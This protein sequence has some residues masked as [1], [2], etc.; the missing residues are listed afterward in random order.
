M[1]KNRGHTKHVFASTASLAEWLLRFAA[2]WSHESNLSRPEAWK[3]TTLRF[4]LGHLSK[5]EETW[6]AYLELDREGG[7]VGFHANRLSSGDQQ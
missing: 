3:D 2:Q 5:G 4:R 1:G 6:T 7:V